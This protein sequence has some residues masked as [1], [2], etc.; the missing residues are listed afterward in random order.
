[1]DNY[2]FRKIDINEWSEFF[3]NR[4]IVD[5]TNDV[6]KILNSYNLEFNVAIGSQ[7]KKYITISKYRYNSSLSIT[8]FEDEWIV[9]ADGSTGGM[10]MCDQY[11]GLNQLLIFLLKVSSNQ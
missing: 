4:K 7:K 11:D 1:M 9:A 3:S 5:I 6:I 10:Y 8:E 2:F